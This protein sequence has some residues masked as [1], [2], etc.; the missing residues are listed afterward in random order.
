MSH[1]LTAAAHA[2]QFAVLACLVAIA[3]RSAVAQTAVDLPPDVPASYLSRVAVEGEVVGE[4]A[5]LSVAIDVNLT[6]DKWTTVRLAMPEASVLSSDHS[7]RM[8]DAAAVPILNGDP[9]DGL[10]WRFRGLGKHTL[11][12]DVQVPVS[13]AAGGGRQL[14]LTLPPIDL[15]EATVQLLV[16]SWPI[17]VRAPDAVAVATERAEP[18]DSRSKTDGTRITA[19]LPT[20][21]LQLAWTQPTPTDTRRISS[22]DSELTIAVENDGRSLVLRGTQTLSAASADPLAR[23]EVRLPT[24]FTLGDVSSLDGRPLTATP[25][26][27]RTRVRVE[28]DEPPPGELTLVWELSRKIAAAEELELT[29]E[30]LSIEDA[31]VQ[32]GTLGLVG[33]EDFR[34]R[35]NRSDLR[36]VRLIDSLS[37]AR[38]DQP[39]RTFAI[40]TQ[41][42]EIPVTLVRQRAYFAA[43]Q[44]ARLRF[45]RDQ[46]TLVSDFLITVESGRLPELPIDWSPSQPTVWQTPQLVA[47]GPYLPAER[48]AELPSTLSQPG[49]TVATGSLVERAG[50]MLLQPSKPLAGTVHVVIETSR[51]LDPGQPT[52]ITLPT[53]DGRLSDQPLIEVTADDSVEVDL[54]GAGESY[55]QEL[56]TLPEGSDDRVTAEPERLDRFIALAERPLMEASVT[57]HPREVTLRSIAAIDRVQQP[58]MERDDVRLAVTQTLRYDVKYGR[59][60]SVRLRVPESLRDAPTADLFVE[61]TPLLIDGQPVSPAQL[62]PRGPGLFELTLPEPAAAFD[63][64]IGPYWTPAIDNEAPDD[65]AQT[66]VRVPLFEDLETAVATQTCELTQS[67]AG[68]RLVG[69]T[70][71]A[72]EWIRVPVAGSPVYRAEGERSIEIAVDPLAEPVASVLSVDSIA[73]RYELTASGDV[74]V[75]TRYELPQPTLQRPDG[76]LELDIPATA[77]DAVVLFDDA[78]VVFDTVATSRPAKQT[79]LRVPLPLTPGPTT[80]DVQYRDAA[81]FDG[82]GSV[83]CQPPQLVADAFV[84]RSD[85]TLAMP[86]GQHLFLS[87]RSLT[88]EYEWKRL[89]IGYFRTT[90]PEVAERRRDAGIE[91]AADGYAFTATG[92]PEPATFVVVPRSV[93][94]LIGA[95]VTLAF[96]FLLLK[97]P[98]RQQLPI[99]LVAGFVVALVAVKYHE[100]LQVLLQPALL[101]LILAVTA[102]TIDGWNRGEQRAPVLTVPSESAFVP[103]GAFEDAAEVRPLRVG[104]GSTQTLARPAGMTGPSA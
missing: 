33:A 50:G 60:S 10:A 1:R 28:V 22:V 26:A 5:A 32:T 71:P 54:A 61:T 25:S 49:L 34:F 20:S 21:R 29:L 63:L 38:A 13:E 92:L 36:G 40:E 48:L 53:I 31:S 43:G 3:P 57:W 69:T 75:A 84:K 64:Q 99:V 16:P 56:P 30:G 55:L 42:I 18:G 90:R 52:A 70:G 51:P 19:G 76:T 79:R 89:R 72:A 62:Q 27:E 44:T 23:F 77:S 91:L 104:E 24:G 14:D 96:S 86:D 85:I 6:V 39:V 67:A 46:V 35:I 41:P 7:S 100:P 4:R 66:I 98:P 81:R 94:V 102:V 80:L 68:L 65:D 101:G 37:P 88:P 82:V 8:K 45:D 97:V 58:D 59:L 9:A 11:Q 47:V 83:T 73:V 17:T 15:Y 12:L 93:L 95:A 78:A 74:L 87:P 103:A 2:L